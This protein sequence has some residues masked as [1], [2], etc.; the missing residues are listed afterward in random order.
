MIAFLQ[1]SLEDFKDIVGRTARRPVSG[2]NGNDSVEPAERGRTRL[3]KWINPEMVFVRRN[4]LIG[5]H[6]LKNF[7]RSGS[8]AP[9]RHGDERV[10]FG[11]QHNPA[12]EQRGTVRQDLLPV[13]SALKHPTAEARALEPPSANH[14][15][16]VH[17]A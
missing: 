17:A 1:R 12:V 5:G 8:D 4:L 16:H 6:A 3:E 15:D 14:A 13:A 11:L 2:T 7:R 9:I 10:V